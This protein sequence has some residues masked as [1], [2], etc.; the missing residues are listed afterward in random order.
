MHLTVKG[1][2]TTTAAEAMGASA[3]VPGD[4]AADAGPSKKKTRLEGSAVLP[5]PGGCSP[6]GSQAQTQQQQ[7]QQLQPAPAPDRAEDAGTS[8]AAATTA[9]AAAA[10]AA[11]GG[12]CQEA[13]GPGAAGPVMLVLVGMPGS[14]KSTFC[15]K[16]S[17]RGQ[18]EQEQQGLL[19]PPPVWERVNQDSIAGGPLCLSCLACTPQLGLYTL[20]CIAC[21]VYLCIESAAA[22]AG[23]KRGS[24]EQCL[25]AA[26]RAL[27][28]GRSVL[29]D[30]CHVEPDQRRPFVR[31]AQELRVEVSG[32]RAGGAS[33]GLLCKRARVGLW[34]RGGRT[35]AYAHASCACCAAA[36]LNARST[37]CTDPP[38]LPP[39][40]P[41]TSCRCT[42]WC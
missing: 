21:C 40:P 32:G 2:E 3:P 6:A 35:A 30:R 7:Q 18:Q 17:A 31:L 13:T 33:R 16:L 41:P 14:G 26:R 42:A 10:A 36:Q 28:G 38:L 20:P 8:T 15:E 4:A 39:T 5:G 19:P 1:Q 23:N 11:A 9:A 27:L 22:A 37:R 12:G 29:L 25:A 24:R 34:G